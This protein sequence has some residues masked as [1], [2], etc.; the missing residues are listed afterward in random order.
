MSAA[1]RSVGGPAAQSHPP[2]DPALIHHHIVGIKES[3][4]GG[5]PQGAGT[6]S[7]IRNDPR[8]RHRARQ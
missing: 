6:R 4:F 1:V 8:S 5:R 3:L 2:S 7:S